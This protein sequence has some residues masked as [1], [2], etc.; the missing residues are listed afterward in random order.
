MEVILKEDVKNLGKAGEVV[1]VSEGYA[2]NFLFPNNKAIPATEKNIKRIKEEFLKRE[3][4]IKIEKD[5]AEEL[6]NKINGLEILIKER[7]SEDGVLYGSVTQAEIIKELKKLGYEFQ[8]A[9]IIL[10]EH[11]KKVGIYDIMIKLTGDIEA[12]IKI[13]VISDN[14]KK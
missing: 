9:N 5:K 13:K 1:K 6:A 4:N 12:Q 2:R 11:I 8:K 14:G 7:T 3:Q 10:K